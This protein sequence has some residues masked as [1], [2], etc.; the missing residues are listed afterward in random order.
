M[1]FVWSFFKVLF[2]TLFPIPINPRVVK[3][4]QSPNTWICSCDGFTSVFQ[5]AKVFWKTPAI[6]ALIG[7]SQP[8]SDDTPPRANTI[9]GLTPPPDPPEYV[10]T[11][12]SSLRPSS[13]LS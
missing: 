6:E 11:R 10:S 7:K 12:R 4:T 3:A 13:S 9:P 8:P 2:V 5:E 1:S